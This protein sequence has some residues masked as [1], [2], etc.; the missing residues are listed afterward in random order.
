VFTAVADAHA[1][2]P[3]ELLRTWRQVVPDARGAA[4]GTTAT[5][6]E[7]LTQAAAG[8][9]TGPVVVA[10]SVYLVGAVRAALT[11]ERVDP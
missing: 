3:D 10:G 1:H 2:R 11:G 7:A 8:L 5:V 6:A 9:G 4:A